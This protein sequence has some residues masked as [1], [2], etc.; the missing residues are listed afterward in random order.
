MNKQSSK[1][2]ALKDWK[3]FERLC[4]DLLEAE[5]F[6][7]Q[8]EPSV[9]TTGTDFVA[10]ETYRTHDPGRTI[11][12]RWRVQC[13]HYAGSGRNLG[14]EEVESIIYAY[15]ARRSADDGL[16]IIVSSEYTEPAKLAIEAYTESRSHAR[17]TIWN[18]RHLASRL[19]RHVDVACRYGLE[20]SSYRYVKAFASLSAFRGSSVLFISDQSAF[21]H[22]LSREFRA[23]GLETVYLPVW[24]YSLPDRLALFLQ[25][26]QN[27]TFRLI[28]LF[29]GDTFGV[30]LPH[31]LIKW[32]TTQHSKGASMLFFP[33]L[34]WA[35]E[36]GM[37]SELDEVCPVRLLEPKKAL[38]QYG[39]SLLM[40][41]YRKGDFSRLI[42]LLNSESFTEDRYVE[43]DPKEA[44]ALFSTGIESR[45]G[46]S[47]S[48]EF[49]EGVNGSQA[50]WADA[51]G[52]PLLVTRVSGKSRSAYINSCCHACLS[53]V[54]ISSPISASPDFATFTSNV[55]TW[56]MKTVE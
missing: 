5:G 4:A 9:D 3:Q 34:A 37:Y 6:D 31:A 32:V 25:Q 28:V 10:T 38:H 49:I 19:E 33:F 53:T 56:L 26:Y 22:D 7:I 13:K 15:E 55:L 8:S 20:P 54:P 46:V 1:L 12:I 52:N 29:L 50:A 17:V 27:V 35:M 48:I 41:D 16:F 43:Y 39:P 11:R 40:S 44:V 23:H 24:N 30:P 36:R 2:Q 45:F 51:T 47:H 18:G 14:R 21:A 42:W